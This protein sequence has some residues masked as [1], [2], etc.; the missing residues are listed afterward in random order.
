MSEARIRCLALTAGANVTLRERIVLRS[1][2]VHALLWN[3]R[4]R[5]RSVLTCMGEQRAGYAASAARSEADTGEQ[6]Q[7]GSIPAWAQRD[8]RSA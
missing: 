5:P 2:I 7:I 1:L 8:G 4:A 6:G 3:P